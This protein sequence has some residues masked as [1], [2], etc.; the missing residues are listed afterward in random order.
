MKKLSLVLILIIAFGVALSAQE[1]KN[2]A[3]FRFG[4]SNGLTFKRFINSD[5]ALE[6]ILTS[7]WHG[8]NVT[9]LYEVHKNLFNDSQINF[10]YG[11]GGHLGIWNG[12]YNK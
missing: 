4:L 2:A 11:F 1:Y 8:F 12:K 6:G 10:F 3:G 9:G 7:R 5:S